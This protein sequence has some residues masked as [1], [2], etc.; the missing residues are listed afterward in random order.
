MRAISPHGRYSIQLVQ[1]ETQVGVDAGGTLREFASVEPIVANFEMSGLLD[2]EIKLVESSFSF[3]GVA[4]G[5]NPLTTV[6][7][8]DTE[9]ASKIGKW[10]DEEKR[11]VEEQ[12][13]AKSIE[14]GR[15]IV[16]EEPRAPKPWGTYDEMSAEQVVAFAIA[17]GIDPT[18]YEKE[19]LNREEVLVG[20]Q[21][22]VADEDVP[23][24][25]AEFAVQA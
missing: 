16:V 13:I 8:F 14:T 6:S 2:H 15:F 24:A 7:V 11:V 4:E 25:P 22:G 18:R 12:L 23:A 19:N 5:V 10:S 17:G 3:S 20:I 9:V 1:G 21:Y